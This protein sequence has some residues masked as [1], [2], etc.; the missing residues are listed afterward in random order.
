MEA[1]YKSEF[2]KLE[3]KID[4][5]KHKETGEIRFCVM[6]VSTS[7]VPTTHNFIFDASEWI[8]LEAT[9]LEGT[10]RIQEC[11]H[12]DLLKQM[13]EHNLDGGHI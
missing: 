13:E 2:P 3:V 8:R 5:F 1:V 9:D 10:E 12:Q 7:L 6:K 11:F 4:K